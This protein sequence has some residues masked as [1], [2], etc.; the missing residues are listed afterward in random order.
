MDTYLLFGRRYGAEDPA[1]A[2]ALERAHRERHRP[3]CLCTPDGLEMYVARVAGQCIL[4]RMPFTGS[5]HAPDCPSYDTPPGASGLG[6]LLGSAIQE[7]PVSGATLLRLGFAVSTMGSR[8]SHAPAAP[9]AGSDARGGMRL[10]LRGLLHYLWDEAELSRWQPAF[11]GRR[12]WATVRK[13]LQDASAGKIVRGEPL[14]DRLYVPETFRV[15]DRDQINARQRTRWAR[16]ATQAG[17]RQHLLIAI[18]EVKEVCPARYGARLLLKQVPDQAFWLDQVLYRGLR[19]R[20]EHQLSL[21]ATCESL[22]LIAALTFAMQ[23]SGAPMVHELSVMPANAQWL[24]VEDAA[25]LQ[26]TERLAREGRTFRKLLRYELESSAALAVAVLLDTD[27]P[28]ALRLGQL[29]D[30]DREVPP[31]EPLRHWHWQPAEGPMPPLPPARQAHERPAP[32]GHRA[33]P[34]PGLAPQAVTAPR[35]LYRTRWPSQRA[36]AG[37]LAGDAENLLHIRQRLKSVPSSLTNV[38]CAS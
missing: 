20:F 3:L 21:W 15:E 1:L 24:P 13:H 38:R 16:A 9:V 27:T 31:G 19:R 5:L 33:P 10:S 6:Q 18:A 32:P 2:L 17:H 37:A 25:D 28:C 26:L 30:H 22:H 36:S 35:R 11:T 12:S 4:K 34:G 23:P 8:A 29:A 7:D 14:L